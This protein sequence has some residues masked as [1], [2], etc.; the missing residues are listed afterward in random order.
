MRFAPGIR[1]AETAGMARFTT[2]LR[3]PIAACFL[4]CTTVHFVDTPGSGK[5][6][7]GQEK[8]SRAGRWRLRRSR[9]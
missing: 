1:D 3:V 4:A 8:R 2:V 5:T 9:W 6:D 7:P